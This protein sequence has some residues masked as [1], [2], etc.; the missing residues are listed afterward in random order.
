LESLRYLVPSNVIST[1]V[2]LPVSCRHLS[3]RHRPMSANVGQCWTMSDMSTV[4]YSGGHGKNGGSRWNRFV[5]CSVSKLFPFRFPL[6]VSWPTFELPTSAN[7]RPDVGQCRQCHIRV[8]HGRKCGVAVGIALFICFRSKVFHFRFRGRHL[9][10]RCR[11][12]LAVSNPC[13]RVKMLGSL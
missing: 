1:S 12:M 11:A 13:R 7:V 3:C 5:I 2:P 10:Y 4:S 9:S 6:P 8:G